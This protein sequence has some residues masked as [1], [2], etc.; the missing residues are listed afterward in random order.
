MALD[1][2]TAANLAVV[3]I[4]GVSSVALYRWAVWATPTR[5]IGLVKAFVAMHLIFIQIGCT[6][7]YVAHAR[8]SLIESLYLEF[9]TSA[10]LAGVFVPL[11]GMAAF[12]AGVVVY[13]ELPRRRRLVVEPVAP[14][15]PTTDPV[16]YQNR[17]TVLLLIGVA[18]VVASFLARGGFP[19]LTVLSGTDAEEARLAF[20]YGD[21]PILFHSSI[22]SQVYFAFGPLAIM[23]LW[24]S[25]NSSA[26]RQAVTVV[27]GVIVLFLLANSLERTTMVILA[28]WV[29]VAWKYRTG[30]Y[31]TA[32]LVVAGVLF[33]G[34]T[35]VLHLDNIGALGEV[36]YLQ[37]VRRIVVVNAMVNYF[38]FDAFGTTQDFRGGSTYSGYVSAI[39]GR[40]E[41]F[42]N[43]LMTII[44]PGRTIGTAPVGAI[45]ES[46]ANF[47]WAF[48]LPMFLQGLGFAWI[49]RRLVVLRR[50]SAV[51]AVAAAGIVVV[52][53]TASYGGLMAI[54]FSGGV[55]TMALGYLV[56][57]SPIFRRRRLESGSRVASA[58]R[59]RR[60]QGLDVVPGGD[61]QI[62]PVAAE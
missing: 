4:S 44:Y 36:L 30:R 16:R 48:V 55:L 43:E 41:S 33:V 18:Y 22:V 11:V 5:E 26:A 51:G 59:D 42:S 14:A 7:I 34:Q 53:A 39:L 62:S 1:A 27:L 61:D 8:D 38:A 25:R 46:W 58:R 32:V 6:L 15:R 9:T 2:V 60:P 57:T 54:A 20:H 3:A 50:R 13:R 28:L 40:E 31:P 49:D 10:S 37:V 47:S 19:L 17:A 12:V 56:V 24:L 35:L 52:G 23:S 29:L 21:A 45:A